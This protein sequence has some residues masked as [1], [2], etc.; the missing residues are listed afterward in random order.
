MFVFMCDSYSRNAN[1]GCSS[2][3]KKGAVEDLQNEGEVLEREERDGGTDGEHQA[4][5]T[6]QEQR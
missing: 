3:I 6:G 1:K 5:Q 2:S 4:L